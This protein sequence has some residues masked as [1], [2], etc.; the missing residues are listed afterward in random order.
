MGTLEHPNI[1]RSFSAMA[2]RYTRKTAVGHV[3]TIFPMSPFCASLSASLLRPR[4][5]ASRQATGSSCV[6]P[7]AF[8]WWSFGCQYNGW[9]DWLCQSSPFL[10]RTICGTWRRTS[11][12]EPSSPQTQTSGTSSKSTEGTS[13]A[14]QRCPMRAPKSKTS[15]HTV[16]SALCSLKVFANRAIAARDPYV[17]PTEATRK[18]QPSSRL[19]RLW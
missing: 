8:T 17:Y 1:P 19:F 14:G 12:I 6:S 15:R 10:H 7:I 9:A 11:G 18:V 3:G 2:A 4:R 13:S 16:F 5:C